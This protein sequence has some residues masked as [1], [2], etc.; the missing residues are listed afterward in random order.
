[1]DSA[2][3]VDSEL[4]QRV[5]CPELR[6]QYR[7]FLRRLESSKVPANKE[8]GDM[9]LLELFLHPNPGYLSWSTMPP[10]GGPWGRGAI[11]CEV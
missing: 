5:D 11:R 9:E 1:M 10:R 8:L 6:L 2:M 3:E 7:E 4:L